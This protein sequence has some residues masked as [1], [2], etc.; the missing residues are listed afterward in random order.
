MSF[1]SHLS[2]FLLLLAATSAVA[3]QAPAVTTARPDFDARGLASLSVAAAPSAAQERAYA[4]LRKELGGVPGGAPVLL[5][6]PQPGTFHHLFRR[7]GFL[8]GPAPEGLDA[9]AV[10]RGWIAEHR[11][12]LGL[13]SEAVS[14]LALGKRFADPDTGAEHLHFRQEV[15]GLRI[16][17][18]ELRVHL[19][20]EGRVLSVGGDTAPDGVLSNQVALDAQ[21]AL[22]A[23]AHHAGVELDEAPKVERV[24]ADD[25]HRF[26]DGPF[27]SEAWADELWFPH[28]AGLVRAWRVLVDP[29]TDSGWYQIVVDARSGE[30]LSRHDMVQHAA[31]EG[32]A[33]REDPATG[34]QLLLPFV[35]DTDYTDPASPLGWSTADETIGN[36]CDSKDDAAADNETTAGFR[37]VAT[38]DP[39]TFDYPFNNDPTLDL[40]ASVTNLFYLN[41]WLHD[42]LVRLGFDAPSG[43]F[44]D[45]NFGLGGR[46]GDSVLVD[47]Q[48]GRGTN[49]ANF[50]T[51]PD[52]SHPRMQMFIWTRTNPNRDSGFDASVV[53]HELFHGV[54]NR[55][56]GGSTEAGC[57]GGAQG[58]AM[59]EAW[60]D[61]YAC[62]F[63]DTPVVG[64]YVSG[65]TVRGIRRA[66]YDNY[67]FNYGQL[68]NQGGFEVHRDGEIWAAALWQ[69][70]E[71]FAAR[72]GYQAGRCRIE[73]LV[74]DGMKLAPCRPT[75]TDMRDAILLAARLSGAAGDE[76][77]IW[78]GFAG[79]GL[80]IDAVRQGGCT[81]DAD[82]SFDVP[83]ECADC[84]LAGPVISAVETSTPN[85]V[86]VSFT[87]AAGAD[88]H[89][90]LRS[91][92]PCPGACFEADFVEVT[93]GAADATELVDSDA[94]G[95]RLSDGRVFSYRVLAVTG[96]SCT[97]YSDCVEATVRG[98]CTLEPVQITFGALGVSALERPPEA[99]CSMEVAWQQ[100]ASACGSEADLRYNVYRSE[101]PA[102]V[103]GPEHLVASL[104]APQLSW[105]DAAV[106]AAEVTYVVRAEDL[107]T[108]GP[109]PHGGNEERNGVRLTLAPQGAV[110]G[111]VTWI[112][113][114]EGG[115]LSGYRRTGLFVPNDWAIVSDGQTRGGSAWH[116]P[117]ADGGTADSNL[118]LPRVSLG[119]APV[120][121]FQHEFKFE[122]N[123]DGGVIEI[124]TDGGRSWIDLIA[125]ITTGGYATSNGSGRT[126]TVAG[127]MNAPNTDELWTGQNSTDFGNWEPV[128]VDLTPYADTLDAQLRFRALFD[129]LAREPEGWYFDDLEIED[130]LTF[131]TCTSSCT[132]PPFPV[133][134]ELRACVG[135]D[136]SARLLIDASGSTPGSAGWAAELPIVLTHDG[137]GTFAGVRWTEGPVAELVF[138]AG[139]GVG[140]QSVTLT[141]RG[142]DGCTASLLAVIS[143]EDPVEPAVRVGDDVRVV[144]S[145]A[146]LELSFGDVGA[147]RYNLH[148][149]LPG[150]D[151]GA[152]ESLPVA[153]F[154]GATPLILDARGSEGA[155]LYLKV[156]AASDCGLSWP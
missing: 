139:T 120:L 7:D 137:P 22:L 134:P 1:P 145:G 135:P 11:D 82:A 99:T 147:S 29:R 98:R 66:P 112:D 10:A 85:A 48:D 50:G 75:F 128:E 117:G 57:L 62:S 123:F 109:G 39:L 30:L 9:E 17:H 13:S 51:P 25:R 33:F 113:D 58:G 116:V 67:P 83:A 94:P 110:S 32:L 38:G 151:L 35:D 31:T 55:L 18:G 37:G 6:G 12:L 64:A 108:G 144:R 143:L 133:L 152:L 44:Q 96:S 21:G 95:N 76:C 26:A 92:A 3:V 59:G 105:T 72:H 47:A 4:Q 93:R 74:L 86:R 34:P 36:N 65:N 132:D 155:L 127:L 149:A 19:D 154:G 148:R 53:T 90:L 126:L 5:W 20:R 156:F 91:S 28:D 60:S 118:V 150:E 73:R 71:L 79:I 141:L 111:S 61:F 81:T 77:V 142:A 138:P 41:N 69:L 101:D 2:G 46:G 45:D 122:N 87:P 43:N 68:C 89:L 15:A 70:R 97:A 100:L 88:E 14:S 40:E 153:A 78:Q 102:F 140:P 115:E 130:A 129:P 124:S 42:R 80:G 106:P 104:P 125:D 114:V 54:S 49:N 84:T 56:V 107:T 121:R 63:W 119:P 103:P 24:D 146:G 23:A 8:T 27:E 136:G 131:E 16:F 52:G